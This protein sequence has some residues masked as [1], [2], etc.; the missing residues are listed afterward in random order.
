MVPI[1]TMGQDMVAVVCYFSISGT[2][3]L[4]Q[5]SIIKYILR[6]SKRII[7]TKVDIL[8]DIS[9]SIVSKQTHLLPNITVLIY[10]SHKQPSMVSLRVH[11]SIRL[12]GFLIIL[13]LTTT[14]QVNSDMIGGKN[15]SWKMK[16]Q[17]H[18]WPQGLYRYIQDNTYTIKFETTPY[19]VSF[20]Y[21]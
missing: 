15:N 4:N 3:E 18:R 2:L 17:S 5:D 14:E 6:V 16:S 11:I 9:V 8:S 12:A 10:D 21:S 19:G 20:F 7:E 13:T 1:P